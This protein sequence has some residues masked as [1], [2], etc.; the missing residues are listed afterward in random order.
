VRRRPRSADDHLR[1]GDA[2]CK[3]FRYDDAEQ[4]Y[5][6]AL[7]LGAGAAKWRLQKIRD[8]RGH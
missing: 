8:K 7:E 6:R 4:H 2:L 5:R 1:L 3:V